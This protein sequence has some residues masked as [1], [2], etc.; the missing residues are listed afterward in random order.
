MYFQPAMMGRQLVALP[1]Q[2]QKFT[3]SEPSGCFLAVL[4]LSAK[5]PSAFGSK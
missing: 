2:P 1:S 3:L 5:A 4:L